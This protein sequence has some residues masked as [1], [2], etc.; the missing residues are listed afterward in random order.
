MLYC[1]IVKYT[2]QTKL[3]Q[4]FYKENRP[5]PYYIRGFHIMLLLFLIKEKVRNYTY[6]FFSF[7]DSEDGGFVN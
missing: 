7:S 1:L 4:L 3:E 2:I 5:Y 6:F